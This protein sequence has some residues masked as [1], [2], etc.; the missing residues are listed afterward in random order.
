MFLGV[1][2]FSAAPCSKLNEKNQGVD[3]GYYHHPEGHFRQAF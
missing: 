2:F 3:I 1:V